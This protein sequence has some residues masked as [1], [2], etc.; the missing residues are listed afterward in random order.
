MTVTAWGPSA[1]TGRLQLARITRAAT[2][3]AKYTNRQTGKVNSAAAPAPAAGL[4]RIATL[5]LYRSDAVLR[6][7][8][9]LQAHPLTGECA[10]GLNP[11]DALALGLSHGAK[12]KVSG[13]DGEVELPVTVTRMVPR[14]GAWLEKTWPATRPLPPNGGMLTVTRA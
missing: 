1:T 3:A 6:R 13:A 4:Q 12:A 14:G 7:A 9:G 5:P 10:I 11:E 2:V 8:A